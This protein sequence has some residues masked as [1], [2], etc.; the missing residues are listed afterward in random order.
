[1]MKNIIEK[2]ETK[3]ETIVKLGIDAHARGHVVCRQIDGLTPQPVQRFTEE[4]LLTWVAKQVQSGTTI[5]SCYEAGPCGYGLHR[6]LEKIG[7][8]NFVVQP[9]RL[10]ELGK[11]VKNDKLDA[12]R[13]VQ[14]LDRY[15]SGNN[16]AIAIV[17][18]PSKEEELARSETR[19]REQL[20]GHRLR[21]IQQGNALLLYYGYANMKGWWLPLK[22]LKICEE[23]PSSIRELMTPYLELIDKLTAQDKALVAAIEAKAPRTLPYALGCYTYEVLRREVGDWNRF[24]NRRE[25]G[26]YTGLCPRERSSGGTRRQGPINKHGNPRVRAALIEL[27]WRFVNWHLT[28]R[29]TQKYL[30]RCPEGKATSAMKKKAIVAMA[31]QLAID[32]WRIFTGRIT[33]EELGLIMKEHI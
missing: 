18:I 4:K 21:A 29:G 5:Y 13:L 1:M 14:R 19:E 16:K 2:K 3:S 10:D 6:K 20:K 30:K 17:R 15:V 33:P 8:K 23:V 12:Q 25:V 27:S 22:W 9:Q 7:V 28:Y 31:R 24:N 11:G 26:S 32:L